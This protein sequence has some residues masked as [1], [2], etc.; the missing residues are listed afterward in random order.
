LRSA[1]THTFR[2]HDGTALF[3]RYWPADG[4]AA[5][6]HAVVL[7]HRGHEHSGRLQHVVDELALPGHA[8]FAWDARGHGRSPGRRGDSPSFAASVKDLDRFIRHIDAEHAIPAAEIAI[9]AQSM[10]AVLAAAWVHDYAPRVRCLVLT[11]PAFA[12][13]LYV[14]FARAGL[15]LLQRLHGNAFINSYVKPHMLTHDAERARS[16]A[17]DPLVTRAISVRVL[18]GLLDT[19]DRIVADAQAIRVPVQVLVSASDWVVRREPQDRFFQRLGSPVKELHLLE[20]FLHDTLGE[21]DR[22]VALGHARRFVVQAFARPCE[23]PAAAAEGT[24]Y[25]HAEE[26]AL[27]RPLPAR[28]LK[29]MHFGLTRASMRTLGRLSAGIRL[30]LETGF[31]S[32]RTLDYV[33]R[34]RAEGAL[35]IGRWIDRTYLDAIGWRGVRLRRRHLGEAIDT[36]ARTLQQ[37]ALPVRLVDLAAGPG[38]YLLELLARMSWRADG[39]VLRDYEAA[40]VTAARAAIEALGYADTARSEQADAFDA[41]AVQA[42][43]PAPTLAVVSGLYELFS[44]NALVQCSLCAL[45]QVMPTGGCLVYTGQPWHPQLELIARTLTSHRGGEPWIMRRRTQAELDEL[46]AAAGFRKVEQWIDPWGIFT[47]SLAQRTETA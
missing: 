15:G 17:D 34:N 35:V 2:T 41:A 12:V 22:A 16:Y 45:G 46:V 27:R 36:A 43:A 37:A 28:S 31:D 7:L 24:K 39:I 32:G 14:P 13:K 40:N 8:M 25:T 29:R 1:S 20:G 23:L 6:Q 19:A 4:S 44:D 42:I 26:Q 5:G 11:S 47:V 21:R 10:A 18:L 33:Y 3:Y 38:R 9:V 30:G